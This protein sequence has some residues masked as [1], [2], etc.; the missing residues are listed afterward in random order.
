LTV[1]ESLQSKLL[2]NGKLLPMEI[3]PWKRCLF[4]LFFFGNH[5]NILSL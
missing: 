1:S 3:D 2:N 4:Q 5:S